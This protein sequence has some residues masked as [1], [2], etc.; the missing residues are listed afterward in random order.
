MKKLGEKFRKDDIFFQLFTWVF[1]S[2]KR[3]WWKFKKYSQI[4]RTRHGKVSLIK[5][6]II[7]ALV[8]IKSIKKRPISPELI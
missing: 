2:I 8:L 3:G 5:M 4:K 1:F 6:Q 7:E